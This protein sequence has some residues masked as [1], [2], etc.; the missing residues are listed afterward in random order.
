M[1]NKL[2]FTFNGCTHLLI[3]TFIWVQAVIDSKAVIFKRQLE[4]APSQ[5]LN[6]EIYFSIPGTEDNGSIY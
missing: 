4:K 5:E 3:G 1:K 6:D 2:I